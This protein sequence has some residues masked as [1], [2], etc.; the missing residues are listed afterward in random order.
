MSVSVVIRP[1]GKPGDLGWVVMANGERYATEFGWNTDYEPF[2]ARLVA[3]FAGLEDRERNQGWIAELDGRRV[4]C[5]FCVADDDPLT[6][7]LRILL[8]DPLARGQGLGV[9]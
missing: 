8:V 5:V 6:A 7:R 2:I 4:G 9:R 1:L 3:D